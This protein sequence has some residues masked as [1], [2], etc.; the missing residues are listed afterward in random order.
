[1]GGESL[2]WEALSLSDSLT[3]RACPFSLAVVVYM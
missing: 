3:L 1:M 2:Y